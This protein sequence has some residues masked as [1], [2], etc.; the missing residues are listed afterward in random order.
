MRC[1]FLFFLVLFLAAPVVAAPINYQGQLQ[2]QGQPFSGTANLEFRLFDSVG[3]ATQIGPEQTRD[4]VSV[5][6]GLFQ[7]ELDFG[8]NAFDGSARFLEVRVNGAPL[9]PRQAVTATPVALYALAG[10]EGPTGPQ[11]P[12]GEAGPTG[13]QGLKGDQGDTG[14]TG[15]QG[16]QGLQGETGPAGPQGLKGDQGDTGATG[17]Q[18]PQG[19][20][21]ET[22]PEGPQGPAGVANVVGGYLSATGCN[23]FPSALGSFWLCNITAPGAV[24]YAVVTPRG[25]SGGF[26]TAHVFGIS[27]NTIEVEVNAEGAVDL[28]GIYYIVF[29]ADP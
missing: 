29:L 3:G 26:I 1:V 17:P 6:G 5:Q 22:G 23:K 10:N 8:A 16:P 21:G 24:Q 2:Q 18:G 9:T 20:Q 25:G 13:P 14:A 28:E 15:P 7:V 27:G 12:Q 11:G 19:P 4:E